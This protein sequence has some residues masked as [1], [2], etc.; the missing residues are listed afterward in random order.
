MSSHD[1]KSVMSKNLFNYSLFSKVSSCSGRL[2]PPHLSVWT[3]VSQELL[4]LFS[5]AVLEMLPKMMKFSADFKVQSDNENH[6]IQ[7]NFLGVAWGLS[8]I[9]NY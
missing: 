4:A 1:S 9:F 3:P 5:G 6:R 2:W 7:V 8:F